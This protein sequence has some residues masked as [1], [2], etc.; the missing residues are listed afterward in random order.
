MLANARNSRRSILPALASAAS[1]SMAAGISLAFLLRFFIG[2]LHCKL[3]LLELSR[4]G[5]T[6][7]SSELPETR[8]WTGAY[9]GRTVGRRE[10]KT[11]VERRAERRGQAIPAP[12]RSLPPL[13]GKGF[14]PR[15]HAAG[16]R[17][18]NHFGVSF[19]RPRRAG[20]Q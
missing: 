4:R 15:P 20:R 3:V 13:R 18:R 8:G 10:K 5:S 7:E 14:P 12:R 6:A 11:P 19:K 16:R 1:A 17:A 9:S 2:Y